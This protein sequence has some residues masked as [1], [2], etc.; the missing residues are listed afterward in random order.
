MSQV[1]ERYIN[2]YT[3]YQTSKPSNESPLDFLY[4]ILAEDPFH[5]L[6]LDFIIDLPLSHRKNALLIIIDKFTKAIH[7]I[8]YTK[9]ITTEETT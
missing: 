7:L 8:S 4:P 5:T 2:E 9:N 6:A 1:I 3:I